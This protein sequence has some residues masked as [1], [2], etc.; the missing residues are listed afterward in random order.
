MGS[1]KPRE[2]HV[3][4]LRPRSGSQTVR[5]L[6]EAEAATTK[7]ATGRR[8]KTAL[9]KQLLG[10][11]FGIR[12]D[13]TTPIPQHSTQH[14]DN[15]WCKPLPPTPPTSSSFAAAF[16]VEPSR[17]PPTCYQVHQT[18]YNYTIVKA[19]IETTVITTQL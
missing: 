19:K 8:C 4:S 3:A 14:Y 15:T 12:Q 17:P 16:L 2:T 1:V 11:G 13:H 5:E 7:Q 10:Y 9:N 18:Y 6:R